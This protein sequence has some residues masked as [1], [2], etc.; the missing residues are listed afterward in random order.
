MVLRYISRAP[1]LRLGSEERADVKK[2]AQDLLETL[3]QLLVLNGA[4]V[5]VT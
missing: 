3:K 1:P 4:T 2:V 5:A